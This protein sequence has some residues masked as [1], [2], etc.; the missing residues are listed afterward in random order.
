MKKSFFCALFALGLT[1]GLTL[2]AFSQPQTGSIG[3]VVTDTEGNPLP[4]V[5]VT[6]SSE[7][8]MGTRTYLTSET[9]N[10]RFPALP[11]GKYKIEAELAGFKKVIQ[12]GLL[13]RVGMS[14]TATFKMEM[15]TLEE[16]VTVTAAPPVID[17]E[18]SK[19]SVTLDKDLIENIP[20]SRDIYD[21][22]NAVPGAVSEDVSYRR[23]TSIHGATVLE[24][25]YALDGVDTTDPSRGY[26]LTN[27]N[28]EIIEETEIITGGQPAE[29]GQVA[30]A[31]IN[32]VTRS[33]GNRFSGGAILY[34]TSGNFIQNLWSDDQIESMKVLKPTSDKSWIEGSLSLGGPVLKDKLWFFANGRYAQQEKTTNFIPFTDP[35]GIY[36]GPYP[37]TMD[38]KN[39]SLKLSYQVTPKIKLM[40]L[41]NYSLVNRNMGI[42]DPAPYLVKAAGQRWVDV[43]NYIATLALN[44]ILSQSTFM[45]IRANIAIHDRPTLMQPE[46]VGQPYITDG[47]IPYGAFTSRGRHS[48]NYM[49]RY[50][51]EAN[52]THFVDS[53]LGGSHQFKAGVDLQRGFY[54]YNNWV[55]NNM[56]WYWSN[57]PYY[58]GMTTWKGVPNIG[59][60]RVDFSIYGTEN[61]SYQDDNITKKIGA[62]IQDSVTFGK[63]LTLNIGIRFDRALGSYIIHDKTAS[64][65]PLSI[66]LG[67]TLVSPYLA[68]TYPN[69]WPQGLNPFSTMP[70]RTL[71]N[72]Q[73]WNSFSPRIGLTYDL[74]GN[75]KTAL[76]LAFSRYSEYMI[77]Q[78]I[79]TAGPSSVR[80]Y[81][82]DT[83]NNRQVDQT[84]D[85][86]LY[87]AT[88]FST[89]HQ[90]YA[91]P[92][93]DPDLTA[94]Y[95]DEYSV[96]IF[97]ELFK[98]FSLGVNFLY[99]QKKNIY[100]SVP[101][102]SEKNRYWYHPDH[103]AI[104]EY[105]VP[106]TAIV[107][108]VGN[109]PDRTVTFYVR[110]NDAPPTF[111]QTTNVPEL[112][113]NYVGVDFIFNKRLADRWQFSGSI[114]YSKTYGNM[115]GMYRDAQTSSFSVNS[116]I[117]SYGR[118]N[119]DR[120]LV[121]KL[122]GSIELPYRVVLS[123]YYRHSSGAPWGRDASI[124]PPAVWTTANN[125][126]REYTT[127]P[128][129]P[130]DSRRTRGLD[131]L[132]LR[133][134]KEFGIGS[135]GK[136][137]I[138]V[139][140]FNILGYST[141]SVGKKVGEGLGYYIQDAIYRY[142]PSAEN[143]SEP[144][145]IS[146]ESTYNLI[147]AV[148]GQRVFKFCLR[149]SF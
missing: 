98:N 135:L 70:G 57:G 138:F 52:T 145:K 120:P 83:N 123:T 109:D 91:R 75:R 64:G 89:W 136:V 62:F 9:G 76:K 85:I 81:W 87:T 60:G 103:P 110:R 140:A 100:A 114:T 17:V 137:G 59:Y 144:S 90:D 3:G 88:D 5:N 107:P 86:T 148:E 143:V 127:V 45:D 77:A 40:S 117:N 124:R 142:D 132:D 37:W 130:P 58:Y 13:V 31:Y 119:V 146:I 22:F 96:G 18:Q 93:T 78:G 6:V 50:A 43:K 131:V 12:E 122:M 139:D 29:V 99:K 105:Y 24:N 94:P 36:H 38:E 69:L 126:L 53:F 67:D 111:Y 16:Q 54:R 42:D 73:V 55:E 74:F 27:I 80:F 95:L 121:I 141:V 47:A 25:V 68:A 108:G 34:Y 147:A 97:H 128:I 15:A 82:Y 101:Y 84:D 4:G 26:P 23:T 134:E 32:V 106:F 116:F 118:T 149:F 14:I 1:M 72:V 51:I 56:R 113:R 49:S 10:F 65:H 11:P 125:T 8:L 92:G 44:Y 21:I 66:W 115:G 28:Y 102:E 35:L 61:G 2:A 19:I 104:K 33:G 7:V 30:G 20:M 129:E 112:E 39:A 79:G 48:H 63:R 133:L 46:A 41:L 71:N